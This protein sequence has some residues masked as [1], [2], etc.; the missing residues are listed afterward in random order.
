MI[1]SVCEL[2]DYCLP[3]ALPITYHSAYILSFLGVV[4]IRISQAL[5][6]QEDN[7][8]I[9]ALAVTTV[10]FTVIILYGLDAFVYNLN[11]SKVESE[12]EERSTVT[13]TEIH[14]GAGRNT[15]GEI[16]KDPVGIMIMIYLLPC[17][18]ILLFLMFFF[19]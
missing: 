3:D 6:G 14:I 11:I 17:N 5:S 8:A 13:D 7:F 19:L 4:F 9:N 10:N 1:I 2:E 15:M 12:D 18:R 16:A